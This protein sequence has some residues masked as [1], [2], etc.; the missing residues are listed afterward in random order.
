M[1]EPKLD[2]LY[3]DTHSC[4]SIGI[5]DFSQYPTTF[6]IVSPSIEITIPSGEYV[7]LPFTPKSVNIYNSVSLKLSCEEE[8]NIPLPDGIYRFKYT[9]NPSAKYFVE[10]TFLRIDQL[11]EKYDNAFLKLELDCTSS[12]I[13]K[14]ELFII[15]LYIGEAIAAANKCAIEL[16]MKMYRKASKL[17]D[18]FIDCKCK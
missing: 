18:G 3:I 4:Y 5:A 9:M 10:K 16:S 11:Q 6:N 17:L 13:E 2:L 8:D 12:D 7:T 14:K 15:S 1:A